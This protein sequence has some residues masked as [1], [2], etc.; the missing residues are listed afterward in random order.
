[1]LSKVKY[2]LNALFLGA[3]IMA[4]L[5]LLACGLSAGL[6][7]AE[8]PRAA[9]FGLGFPILLGLNV[10]FIFFWLIFKARQVWVPLVG[11]LCSFTYI[12]DYCPIN[13]N[14]KLPEDC[15][16]VLTYN[17]HFMGDGETDEQGNLPIVDYI[18]RMGA[19]IV[20]LQEVSYQKGVTQLECDE[21]F[22][23]AGYH[24]R[25]FTDGKGEGQVTYSLLPIVHQE[26]IVYE[27]RDNGSIATELLYNGD[28]ILVVNN[29]LESYKLSV[30]DKTRYKE[31]IKD[32]EGKNTEDNS[33]RLLKKM[34][35]ASRLRGP[36]ADS[37]CS[38]IRRRALPHV[39][40]CGDFNDSPISYSC[41][42][43]SENLKSAFRESGN[44]PGW[45]YNQKGFY[46]RIDHIF[47]SADYRT[48][49]THL[50]K[51]ATWSDH[52]PMITHL[53][54]NKMGAE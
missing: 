4:A 51:T 28:T 53:K 19:D 5:L 34:A 13:W 15:L 30:E 21:A 48:Y 36:Q 7:P 25:H 47:V 1:M 20:C 41:K 45:S 10:G 27:S 6:N 33:R 18:I 9:L 16:T 54:M 32:P 11:L 40:A 35:S 2:I 37:V 39:I 52:Y 50:D 3:N 26:R 29:H 42:A 17:T 22:K 14:E 44:G 43:F 8:H 38:Y 12:Y 49:D 46:F 24:V 31:I 23:K